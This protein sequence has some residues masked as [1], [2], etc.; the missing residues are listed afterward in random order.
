MEQIKEFLLK[1]GFKQ[2]SEDVYTNNK[3]ALSY[4]ENT[5]TYK[6]IF[7]LSINDSEVEIYSSDLNIY[8][9]VGVLTWYGLIDKN[10]V[11]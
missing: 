7:Q 2:F 9:L 4:L 1:N 11:Q 10:Y 6:I 5:K 8:W 3:C